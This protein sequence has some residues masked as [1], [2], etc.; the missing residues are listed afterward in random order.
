MST[1]V[2]GFQSSRKINNIFGFLIWLT[3][4]T[5]ILKGLNRPG[6]AM[7]WDSAAIS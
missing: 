5:S 2:I 7:P 6:D 1:N 4:Y 3:K